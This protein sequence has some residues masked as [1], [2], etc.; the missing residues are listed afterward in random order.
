MLGITAFTV[1]K[2][3]GISNLWALEMTWF[4]F[5]CSGGAIVKERA[6]SRLTIEGITN[7][8]STLLLSNSRFIQFK[9]FFH[10]IA[11]EVLI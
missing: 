9:I 3:L 5:N 6:N 4:K 2:W 11:M 7:S 8:C 1:D 10:F